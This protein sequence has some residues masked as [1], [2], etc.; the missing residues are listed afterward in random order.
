MEA[1]FNSRTPGMRT[2]MRDRQTKSRD[3]ATGGTLAQA[4]FS[5]YC[6][7][8]V[9]WPDLLG[10]FGV[11]F[12]YHMPEGDA[13]TVAGI[14]IEGIESESRSPGR[15]ARIWLDQRDLTRESRPA[16]W[17]ILSGVT[18]DVESVDATPFAISRLVIKVSDQDWSR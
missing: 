7:P 9:L 11:E 17:I 14:F 4:F 5:S 15:Y 3:A 13:G 12:E 6:V 16:D 10:Q 8:D 1:G 18:Y 2:R